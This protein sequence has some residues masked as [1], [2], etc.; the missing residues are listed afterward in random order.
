[1]HEADF[2]V[3]LKPRLRAWLETSL[4][5]GKNRFLFHRGV[6]IIL[7]SGQQQVTPTMKDSAVSPSTSSPTLWCKIQSRHFACVILEGTSALTDTRQKLPL[8]HKYSSHFSRL[9]ATSFF[10]MERGIAIF[11]FSGRNTSR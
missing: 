5:G 7:V 10:G 11:N 6:I 2:L 4:R 8:L 9:S 1:M 3:H